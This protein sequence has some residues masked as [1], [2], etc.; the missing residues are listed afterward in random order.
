MLCANA[1][2]MLASTRE[3][4]TDMDEVVTAERTYEKQGRVWPKVDTWA[5]DHEYRLTDWQSYSRVYTRSHR[6]RRRRGSWIVS[7]D[8]NGAMVHVSGAVRPMRLAG[9]RAAP[10]AI[11]AAQADVDELLASLVDHTDD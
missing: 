3:R 4:R 8:Q 1:V 11:S 6:L 5:R 10:N 7:I 2:D 9:Q